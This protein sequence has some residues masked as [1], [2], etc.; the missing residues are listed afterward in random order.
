MKTPRAKLMKANLFRLAAALAACISITSHAAV[1]FT[2]PAGL[3]ANT[4]YNTSF[5]FGLD[6]TVNTGGYVTSIGVYNPFSS[7]GVPQPLINSLSVAIYD[8]N[9]TSQ[10]GGTLTSFS[11]SDWA[12]VSGSYVLKS[13]Q[14]GGNPPEG[15]FLAP[16]TYS[17]V[18]GIYGNSTTPP[19]TPYYM[20]PQGGPSAITFND[21]GGALTL[22]ESRFEIGISSFGLPPNNAPGS[23]ADPTFGAGTFDFTPVPEARDFALIA[24]GGMLLVYA[25]RSWLWKRSARA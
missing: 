15:V 19:T 18:A 8:L 20:A 1:V 23:W 9:T 3:A 4:P 13:V 11:G 12:S 7:G 24:A 17:I 10:V 25:G 22:G 2:A 16:G 14:G 5:N 21:N 6:F